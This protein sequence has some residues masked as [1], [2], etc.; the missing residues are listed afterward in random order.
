MAPHPA[1]SLGAHWPLGVGQKVAIERL[2]GCNLP[3]IM[4]N[5]G[6][7]LGHA[8]HTHTRTR[9]LEKDP[10][11]Y[12]STFFPLLSC[13]LKTMV[14]IS[15]LCCSCSQPYLFKGEFSFK[16]LA[17]FLKENVKCFGLGPCD[18]FL[19]CL[20]PWMCRAV[21]GVRGRGSTVGTSQHVTIMSH[22]FPGSFM[23]RVK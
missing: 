22:T 8:V 7:G 11:I 4:L 14:C 3:H 21:A 23:G 12:D 9:T 15:N 19:R 10:A 13:C 17:E 16:R 18:R 1:M 5:V 2:L 20:S 6:T